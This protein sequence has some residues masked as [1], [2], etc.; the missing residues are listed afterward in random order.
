MFGLLMVF[1]IL[2]IWGSGGVSVSVSARQRGRRMSLSH[3]Y[4]ADEATTT[5]LKF[6]LLFSHTK[7]MKAFHMNLYKKIA[8]C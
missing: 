6:Y 8:K 2:V 7:Q 5:L 1:G 3:N 4:R